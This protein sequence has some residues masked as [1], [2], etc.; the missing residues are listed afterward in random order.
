MI[1]S[2]SPM[3]RQSPLCRLTDGWYSGVPF[4]QYRYVK[5]P[6]KYSDVLKRQIKRINKELLTRALKM[7]L[8]QQHNVIERRGP[9]YIGCLKALLTPN[10]TQLQIWTNM[11][12][13]AMKSHA[14]FIKWRSSSGRIAGA[15]DPHYRVFLL[16]VDAQRET[17]TY[18]LRSK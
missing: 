18:H 1:R 17:I 6:N 16:G 2:K 4:I 8:P 7:L 11:Q 9:E 15:R 3:G 5:Y 10:C 14:L 12:Q 13:I